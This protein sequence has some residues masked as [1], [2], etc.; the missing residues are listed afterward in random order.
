MNDAALLLNLNDP[1]SLVINLKKLLSSNELRNIL[2]AKGKL[3]Y[4]EIV[5]H[6]N[7]FDVLKKIIENFK[8]RRDCWK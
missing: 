5:S 1:K 3:R 4:N 6:K 2:I 8:S 7:N